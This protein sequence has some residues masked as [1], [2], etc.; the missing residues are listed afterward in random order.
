[1]AAVCE[2]TSD[3]RTIASL[4]NRHVYSAGAH[5]RRERRVFVTAVLA[6]LRPETGELE[7]VRAGHNPPLLVRAGGEISFLKPSGLAFGMADAGTFDPKLGVETVVLAP[8][9]LV[10]LYSDGITEAMDR[11]AGQ[12]SEERLIANLREPA[13][14]ATLCARIVD[15]VNAFAAGAPQHDD[16]SLVVVRRTPFPG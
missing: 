4:S 10:L 8:G 16:M 11:E 3:M 1:M 6:A 15:A 13:D 5:R 9:D 14:A 2:E 7:L 12:F